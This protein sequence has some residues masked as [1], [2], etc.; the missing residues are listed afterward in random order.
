MGLY[1][2]KH[3][4]HYLLHSKHCT[5]VSRHV[6][7]KRLSERLAQSVAAKAC[8]NRGTSSITGLLCAVTGVGALIVL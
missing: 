2:Q 5:C 3:L 1:M 8:E 6:S 4:D 7:K